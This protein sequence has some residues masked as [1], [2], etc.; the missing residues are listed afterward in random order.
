MGKLQKEILLK[1]FTYIASLIFIVFMLNACAQI[2]EQPRPKNITFALLSEVT[3]ERINNSLKNAAE[4]L[5]SNQNPDGSLK[6]VYYPASRRFSSQ[7]NVLRQFMATI[8]L[9]EYYNYS[10][11]VSYSQAFRKNL[12]YNLK[13][14]YVQDGSIG[15][16]YFDNTSKLGA[17]A[18]A[19]ISIAR[20]NSGDYNNYLTSLTNLV[21]HLHNAD[22]SF[23]TFYIPES[24]NTNQYFYP[25]ETMLAL[26]VLYEKT[27]DKRYIDTVKQ[28]FDFYQDYYRK[29]MNPAFIPWMS[30][31]T[32][33]LYKETGDGNYSSYIFEINDWLLQIQ[34]KKCDAPERLGEFYAPEHPEYGPPHA[35][36]TG[37]YIEGLSYAYA[38]AKELNDTGRMESYKEAILLGTRSQLQLQFSEDEASARSDAR[39]VLGG[40]RTSTSNSAIRIDNNQH[41]IM[42]FI[43]VGRVLSAE[44]IAAFTNAHPEYNCLS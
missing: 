4:W 32:Y 41:T 19:I 31:A 26:M 3:P 27:H 25:G 22:G 30:M 20:L 35:A 42:A 24:L 15:H 21:Y 39:F 2:S 14:Y 34:N 17:A 1:D 16:I 13:T 33:K 44:D 36:S 29:K 6:Y 38:L 5:L 9:D 10:G 37:I 11:N 18:F 7:N 28:S 8:A 43:N 12:D 40:I 23:Q